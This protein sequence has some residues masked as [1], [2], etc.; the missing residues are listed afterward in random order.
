[1]NC[2]T[3]FFLKEET[4]KEDGEVMPEVRAGGPFDCSRL[5]RA[6]GVKVFYATSPESMKSPEYAAAWDLVA[7]TPDRIVGLDAEWYM[8]GP[9]AVLQLATSSQCIVF[10]LSQIRRFTN[11]TKRSADGEVGK[12]C[13][14][15]KNS[16]P[17]ET[18]AI[19]ADSTSCC[20]KK[21]HQ[22]LPPVLPETVVSLL[23]HPD[24]LKVGVNVSGD[25]KRLRREGVALS[26]GPLL[27]L[28]HAAVLLRSAVAGRT[29]L[30]ALA[31]DVL[32]LE[33]G[34]E[35][36]V[37]LSNWE[38]AMGLSDVQIAYA[39]DDA[40]ASHMIALKLMQEGSLGNAVQWADTVREAGRLAHRAL[41]KDCKDDRRGE[42]EEILDG[43]Q[44]HLCSPL[45]AGAPLSDP[46]SWRSRRSVLPCLKQA[47][48]S[49]TLA[50]PAASPGDV[51]G[52]TSLLQLLLTVEVLSPDRVRIFYCDQRKARWYVHH[53]KL[54][55]TVAVY[56][57][58]EVAKVIAEARGPSRASCPAAESSLTDPCG[59]D[60]VQPSRELPQGY[61]VYKTIQ[62]LFH[63]RVKTKLCMNWQ[64]GDC[65]FGSQC[66]FAHGPE[67]LVAARQEDTLHRGDD[68]DDNGGCTEADHL[69]E[70]DS[71][72]DGNPGHPPPSY[73]ETQRSFLSK[74][75]RPTM[76]SLCGNTTAKHLSRHAVVPP[77]LRRHLPPPF[78]CGSVEDFRL[79]CGGCN[80]RVR[81]AYNQERNRLE[82]DAVAMGCP[83]VDLAVVNR[84]GRY[85]VLLL[86]EDQRKV[87]PP[88]RRNTL[89][90]FICD[91]LDGCYTTIRSPLRVKGDASG[92]EATEGLWMTKEA[93][94]EISRIVP[95]EVLAQQVVKVLV[96]G[97]AEKATL[98]VR[99]WRDFFRSTFRPIT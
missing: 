39:A 48:I 87:L 99:R 92:A 5:A 11:E 88:S 34:K 86:N 30:G 80:H 72:T 71:A 21:R 31:E 45:P 36:A 14:G 26:V 55:A 77:S 2:S 59:V 73:D 60:T 6:S 91:H 93:L 40:I 37:T 16:V 12:D 15:G 70:G 18:N 13:D 9:T 24:I 3:R 83:V 8:G 75:Q 25:A 7:C 76:C 33:L 79:L 56:T 22:V 98:F 1:M 49:S 63:P 20:K 85:A 97:N 66:P 10:H 52:C 58:E 61:V 84:V 41:Q 62:L 50:S 94:E 78:D 53:K 43:G 54:A 35:K 81:I 67:E 57:E 89:Q 29:G 95:G 28:E 96:G 47:A 65:E 46:R 19:A 74:Q 68:E 90:Q 17:R 69:Q 42:R 27:D 44:K 38:D 23:E 4:A 64:V 32:G 51:M 82:D